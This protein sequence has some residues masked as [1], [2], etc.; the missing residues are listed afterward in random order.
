M[1][2]LY[3]GAGARTNIEPI[4]CQVTIPQDGRLRQMLDKGTYVCEQIKRR[5]RV[6]VKRL[7]L[8]VAEQLV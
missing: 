4:A 5:T 2:D 6:A 7:A 8:A 3:I 1:R